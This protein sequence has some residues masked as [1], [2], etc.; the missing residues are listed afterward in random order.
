MILQELSADVLA[1][2][3]NFRLAV[4]ESFK[5][6]SRGYVYILVRYAFLF[7]LPSQELSADVLAEH[8]NFRLA[9][10]E[11]FKIVSRG[12]GTGVQLGEVLQV[13]N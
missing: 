2:H 4:I 6:V 1:E 7:P 12:Y 3:A 8:A 13:R 11:S 10:I 5:I 9:V